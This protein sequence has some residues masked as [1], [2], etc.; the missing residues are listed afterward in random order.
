[1]EPT[2][3]RYSK[4]RETIL[5]VIRSTVVHPNVEWIYQETQKV[6][7]NISLGTVYRNLTQLVENGQILK[8]KDEAMVRY[9]GNTLHHDHFRCTK[10]GKWYD[11]EILDRKTIESFNQKYKF[12]IK[13]VNLE[14]EGVCENCLKA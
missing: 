1:M 11:I 8:L 13:S 14:L 5:Q 9:D 4:Q 2:K 3:Y 10:C 12:E 6:I 7:P